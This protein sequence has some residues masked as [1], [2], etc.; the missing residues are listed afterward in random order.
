MEGLSAVRRDPP[1]IW[2]GV[3]RGLVY[4]WMGWELGQVFPRAHVHERMVH[5]L[6]E[7]EGRAYVQSLQMSDR[8]DFAWLSLP[9][10]R[11]VLTPT[12]L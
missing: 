3:T 4:Q 11:V 10:L 8:C 7:V 5:G 9:S 6:S 12:F 2:E 1:R